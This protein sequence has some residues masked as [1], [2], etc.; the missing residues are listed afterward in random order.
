M[1]FRFLSLIGVTALIFLFLG[2]N[3]YSLQITKSLYYTQRA[4]A[5]ATRAD[6]VRDKRGTIYFS[7]RI[8]AA[9]DKDFSVIY[10]VPTQVGDVTEASE[11]LRATIGL[12]PTVTVPLLSKQGDQ[13]EELID[14]ASD[15]QVAAIIEAEIP[16]IYIKR[17]LGRQYPFGESASQV[18]GFISQEDKKIAAHGKYGIEA[19]YQDVLS[20]GEDVELTIDPNIQ[21]KA[22]EVLKHLI[23]QW[24]PEGGTVIVEDPKTGAIV[25]MGNYPTFDPN[26]FSKSPLTSF[27]NPAI[28]GL[29]EPG[30]TQKVLTMSAGIDAGAITPE[31][32]YYDKGYF[33]ADGKTIKN[34]DLKAH[35]TMTMTNVIEQSVNTGSVFAQQKMGRATFYDYLLKFGYKELTGIDLPGEIAGRLTPL[36]K[37]PRDINYGTAAYGQGISTTPIRMISA[38]AAIANGGIMMPTHIT[39]TGGIGIARQ[40]M[41][42]ETAAKVAAMMVS[43]VDKAKVAAIPHYHVAGKTGTAYI[44]DF[45]KGGYTDTVINTYVGFAPAS[46]AKFIILIKIDNPKDAPLAGQTVV[47]AFHDLAEFLLNYYDVP[48]DTTTN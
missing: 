39:K 5:Q 31:T 26:D 17:V 15:A 32:T 47:P 2:Y 16:S 7:G 10:A 4:Q 1:K 13:Y 6:P 37:Y 45:K 23:D 19:Q 20:K 21:S 18:I 36:E 12:D 42:A 38:I 34:W 33:T 27:T 14:K 8:P 22:E 41:S 24:H 3:L 28:Q 48:P 46:D 43:A 9:L 30:S 11:R 40:V 29:Y 25:A 35:G 44:P